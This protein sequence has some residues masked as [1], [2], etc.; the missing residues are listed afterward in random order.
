[1]FT[2]LEN[3]FKDKLISNPNLNRKM[4]SYQL[5]KKSPV[6]RWCKYKEAFSSNLVHYILEQ[7]NIRGGRLLDPFAGIG[8]SLFA[9][10]KKGLSSKGIELLPVGAEVIEVR[11]LLATNKKDARVLLSDWAK[12]R[13]W[14]DEKVSCDPI[15]HIAITKGAFP[16]DNELGIARYLSLV[17]SL[18]PVQQR[19]LKFPLMCVLEE[20]SYTEKGGQFLRWDNRSG[21][22]GGSGKFVKSSIENFTDCIV[23]KLCEIEQDLDELEFNP[24][25]EIDIVCGSCLSE[26]PKMS[27]SS[28]A[29]VIT[30]PPYCNRYD[31]TR[32][33]ALELAT[34]FGTSED[35]IKDFR[36]KLMSCTVENKDK[37]KAGLSDV[38]GPVFNDAVKAFDNE[39]ELHDALCYLE[40]KKNSRELN[41]PGIL[42][43]VRNYFFELSLIIFDIARLL[44]PGAIFAMVNDNVQYIG[45]EIP[46][47]LILSSIA[48][49]AGLKV[50]K[51]WVLP[52]GKG[53]SSQQMGVHGRKELRKCVYI[54]KK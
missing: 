4:V 5:S 42:K 17:S 3:R 25:Y 2:A 35:D 11:R 38:F 37:D 19:I 41:N 36:Q 52:T 33:Y 32:T 30:S 9:A 53:N 23:N 20:V 7:F 8:T 44:E 27:S 10:N 48:E 49:S 18:D 29:A 26:L 1:M 24:D 22:R 12:N 46:V 45:L 6:L 13:Y 28:V 39:E 14:L 47:D 21:R 15:N 50:D 43:M 40:R 54:W 34:I 31:Y 51:I 16:P